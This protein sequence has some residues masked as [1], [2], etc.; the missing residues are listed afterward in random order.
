[1]HGFVTDEKAIDPL[2]GQK[3]VVVRQKATSC[4]LCRNIDGQPSCVM[5][6]RTMPP[7]A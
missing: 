6:A 1:M 7:I 4:D 5:P 2:T 3:A